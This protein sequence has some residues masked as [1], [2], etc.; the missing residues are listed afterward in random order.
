MSAYR[1][2]VALSFPGEHRERVETI[3]NILA[4]SLDK[5][6][7][8]YDQWY[9][10]EFARPNLDQYLANLYHKQSW[11]LVF[12]LSRHYAT[13][14]WTGLEWRVG[15]ELLKRKEDARLMFLR[16]DNSDIPGFYSTDGYIDIRD[17]TDGE[18]ANKILERLNGL[19]PRPWPSI[20]DVI[21]DLRKQTEA[22]ILGRCG[23]IRVLS[24]EK[25]IDLGGVYTDVLMLPRRTA[26]LLKTK[27]ELARETQLENFERFGLSS[28]ATKR[29][30]ASQLF[31]HERRIIIYGKPGAGKTTFLKHMATQCALGAFWPS[32]VPVFVTLREYA[33]KAR[34]STLLQ[35]IENQW[36][37]NPNSLSVL[38]HGLA[39]ILLDGLDEVRDRDFKRVRRAIEAFASEFRYCNIA[40]TC[41]IAAREYAFVDFTEV[42][43]ADFNEEQI[44]TFAS[45]WF[46]AY[47]DE[48]KTTAFVSKLQSNRPVCELATSPLL[49]TLLCLVFQERNDFAGSRADLYKL[50]LDVLLHKWDARRNIERD[51]PVGLS[52][53]IL[54]PLLSE[55]AYARFLA[56]EY[57]FEQ[58]NLEKQIG[59]FFRKRNL[60]PES[61]NL[62]PSLVLNTIEAYLG[63]LVAR[64]SNVYSFSHLTFQE[65]LTAQQVVRKPTLLYHI[66]PHIGQPHWREV[67][68]LLAAMLDADDIMLEMKA[69]VDLLVE[70]VPEIQELL[71]WCFRR[72]QQPRGYKRSALR[73]FY[74]GLYFARNRSLGEA[75]RDKQPPS[76][77][78]NLATNTE[79][80]LAR[81]L[82]LDVN[83][84]FEFDR[85]VTLALHLAR[86]LKLDLGL[87]C[88]L[89][90]QIAPQGDVARDVARA[91]VHAL[92][93]VLYF[94]HSE[95]ELARE[96]E[97]LRRELP[98]AHQLEWERRELPAWHHRLREALIRCGIDHAGPVHSRQMQLLQDYHR[99]NLLLLE[100]MSEARGLTHETRQYIEDTMLLPYDEIPQPA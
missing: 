40:L 29:V 30:P 95:P 11:L 14:E 52:R 42:E 28:T 83:L 58:T 81:D 43:M 96:L 93:R 1:F 73:A 7:I 82:G 41:R 39:I 88:E 24:M 45:R 2:H 27:D 89:A 54:E 44:V 32:H 78:V 50:G 36:R 98:G 57:F 72:A 15:R 91:L 92:D 38:D 13:K 87:D 22:D 51:F 37:Q 10:A 46:R 6:R 71:G 76:R 100:C 70:K 86:D 65:Y 12:F 53:S 33:D 23:R 3:A 94:A 55:I 20:E 17:L 74:L 35:F 75:L 68:L 67:W 8:L 18:V 9:S 31:E 25:S 26:N 47:N 99:A 59:D 62:H 80:K 69:A 64:A 61:P 97:A 56:G 49:L 16:L 19:A 66:G 63:L 60:I 34:T 90:S 5:E 84:E 48:E 4:R 77:L 85:Y 21:T 79:F